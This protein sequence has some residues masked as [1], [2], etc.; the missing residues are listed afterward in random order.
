MR[1]AICDDD[2][3]EQEQIEKALRDWDPTQ[4]AE[5]YSNGAS[6][7]EAARRAPHFDIVFLDICMPG[8]DG[9]HIAGQLQKVSPKTGIAFVTTSREYAIDA[10]SLHA[11]HYLVKPVESR[12]VVEAIRRMTEMRA[13]ERKR[14]SFTVGPER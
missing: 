1:I 14:I 7:L 4:K 13:G 6:L 8:E 2:L 10:F 3:R 12:D 11:L 5:K 9:I